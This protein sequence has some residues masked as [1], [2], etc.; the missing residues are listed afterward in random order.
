MRRGFVLVPAMWINELL[1]IRATGT[2][3]RV[4]V[5]LL[6]QVRQSVGHRVKLTNTAAATAGVGRMGK[7]RALD[8]LR[9]AGLIIVEDRDRK[10]P[11]V[12]VMWWQ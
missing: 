9:E 5:L 3:W 12:K 1:R 10:S 4:A 11:L 6:R 7:K 8:Q 2:T